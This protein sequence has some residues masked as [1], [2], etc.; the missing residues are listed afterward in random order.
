MEVGCELLLIDEDLSA[1]NVL[2]KHQRMQKL[3]RDEPIVPLVIKVRALY[4]EQGVS[5]MIVIGG[6]GDWLTVADHV[7]AMDS[8]A[9]CLITE[10]AK[11]VTEAYPSHILQHEN[12]GLV[13]R[14]CVKIGLPGG[15]PPHATSKTFVSIKPILSNPVYD[16]SEAPGGI[17][18]SGLDQLVETGQLRLIIP[19]A[20][21][22]NHLRDFTVQSNLSSSCHSSGVWHCTPL[23]QAWEVLLRYIRKS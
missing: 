12:Y 23:A 5:T 15:R 14:R 4:R 11:R 19:G 17:E 13:R 8:F 1:T 9:P 2:V 22:M 10:E 21:V 6:L 3:I 16:P 7:I 18:L 20:T